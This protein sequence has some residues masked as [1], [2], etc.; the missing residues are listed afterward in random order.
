MFVGAGCNN[1]TRE[2]EGQACSISSSDDPLL[3]CSPAYDLVCIN[4]YSIQVRN[5]AEAVKWDGGIR[6][7]YVCRLACDPARNECFQA[8]DVCCP[9]PIHGKTYG[10]M[11][12]CV[13]LPNC[14]ALSLGKDAGATED[15]AGDGPADG[16]AA[17][18]DARAEAAAPDAAADAVAPDAGAP[19]DAPAD[20]PS[21]GPGEG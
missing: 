21:E 2:Y 4:T 17:P 9:G 11:A 16:P 10:K 3:V 8:G 6:P 13:P 1:T 18:D 14:P 12:G 20:V 5:P 7:I 19:V 15:A